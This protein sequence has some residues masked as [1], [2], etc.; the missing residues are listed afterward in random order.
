[1]KFYEEIWPYLQKYYKNASGTDLNILPKCFGTSNGE[2]KR[3]LLENI[4][5]IG[6]MLSWKAI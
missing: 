6:C 3:I 5:T 2:R 1:M 4:K